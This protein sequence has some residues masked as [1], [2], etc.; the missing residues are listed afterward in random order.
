LR[1]IGELD[2]LAAENYALPGAFKSLKDLYHDGASQYGRIVQVSPGEL[3]ERKRR[4]GDT[5]VPRFVAV[6]EVSSGRK[7]RFAPEPSGTYTLRMIYEQQVDF[8]SDA[9]TSNWLL[10]SAPDLYMWA[11]LSAAEGFLQEDSRVDLW[12]KEYEQAANEYRLDKKK[13]EWGGPLT[14]RPRNVVGE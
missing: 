6:I 14:P 3:S 4:H 7:L 8:L 13:R 9:N 1:E 5:G 12:K 11:S 2:F 10:Q